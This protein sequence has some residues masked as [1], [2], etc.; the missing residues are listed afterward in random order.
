[1]ASEAEPT[2]PTTAAPAPPSVQTILV[3]L[4]VE[5]F[6]VG[7]HVSSMAEELRQASRHIAGAW[8][9]VERLAPCVQRAN[10]LVNSL[11]LLDTAATGM[12]HPPT[13]LDGSVYAAAAAAVAT[14]PPSMGAEAGHS[15]NHAVPTSLTSFAGLA[16]PQSGRAHLSLWSLLEPSADGGEQPTDL[17]TEEAVELRGRPAQRPRRSFGGR[18]AQGLSPAPPAHPPPGRSRRAMGPQ[19]RRVGGRSRTPR[20]SAGRRR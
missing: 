5:Q 17:G 20:G 18:V 11:M 13:Q 1:M 4:Q 8:A 12:V 3:H 15:W 19:L 2:V 9:A 10:E 14:Q 16:G 7:F 6:N